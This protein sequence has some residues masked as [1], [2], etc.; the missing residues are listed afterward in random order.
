MSAVGR[1]I[2]Y[3]IGIAKKAA[4]WIRNNPA[5]TG[6]IALAADQSSKIATRALVVEGE[7]HCF[8]DPFLC[9]HHWPNEEAKLTASFLNFFIPGMLILGGVLI[10]AKAKVLQLAASLI[11]A[12][13]GGNFVD[14]AV[15]DRVTDVLDTAPW[16]WTY[17]VG[18]A[19]MAVGLALLFYHFII[20]GDEKVGGTSYGW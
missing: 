13:W 14:R 4:T 12:G 19:S 10:K 2:R 5:K 16:P 18:D 1:I 9:I 17:T 3:P 8:I 15:Y 11:I 7:K 20:K 6:L